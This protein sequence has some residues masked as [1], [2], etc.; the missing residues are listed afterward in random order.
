VWD[1]VW[2][3]RWRLV[4]ELAP[5][6]SFLDLGGMYGVAG[7]IAFRAEQSGA[8]RVVLFDGMDAS[9]EFAEKHRANGSNVQ[10]IQGDLHDHGAVAALGQFDIVWCTGVIYHTPNPMQQLLHL[11]QLT[12]EHLVLGSLVIPEL[13]GIE[14]GCIFYPGI[15]GEFQ[16]TFARAHGGPERFPGMAVPFDPTPL[17]AYANMWFGISPSALRGMLRFAGFD[18]TDEYMVSPFSIDLLARP[19]G[20]PTDIYPPH[21]Q[22][23]QRVRQRFAEIPPDQVPR[24]AETQ[25]R[26]IR[27]SQ[28]SRAT[29]DG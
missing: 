14:Q 23:R 12:R 18:V 10:F 24:W 28:A 21:G 8:T 16:D 25:L 15:S 29:D 3:N 7:E 17:M 9:D 5:G 4:R 13:P 1:E 6:K 26:E 2:D 20:Q 27:N 19:G 22:S 11:R